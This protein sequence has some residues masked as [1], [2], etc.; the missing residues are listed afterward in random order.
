[1]SNNNNNIN[2]DNNNNNLC[3]LYKRAAGNWFAKCIELQS[4]LH[5]KIMEKIPSQE[6]W[7]LLQVREIFYDIRHYI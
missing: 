1:M 2:S 4:D 7:N 5:V 3:E 6:I